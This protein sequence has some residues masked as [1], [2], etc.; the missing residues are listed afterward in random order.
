MRGHSTRKPASSSY[1]AL[2]GEIHVKLH[3]E[4]TE[5]YSEGRAKDSSE[6]KVTDWLLTPTESCSSSSYQGESREKKKAR[7]RLDS[8]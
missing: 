3:Q 6:G 5:K 7:K 2:R 4:D 1:K 8:V